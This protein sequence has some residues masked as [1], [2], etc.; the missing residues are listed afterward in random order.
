MQ[1]PPVASLE[2]SSNQNAVI[3]LAN[4]AFVLLE[5]LQYLL[6][7]SRDDFTLRWYIFLLEH[8]AKI[9][10]EFL[11]DEVGLLSSSFE[12]FTLEPSFIHEL[13]YAH[14]LGHCNDSW[15]I[16]FPLGPEYQLKH[17]VVVIQTYVNLMICVMCIFIPWL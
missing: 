2:Q 6:F 12:T 17:F 9:K 4:E 3:S 7:Q 13:T 14:L 5:W 8:F 10:D 11:F 16:E 15:N 1:E